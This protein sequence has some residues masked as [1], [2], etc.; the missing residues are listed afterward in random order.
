[1]VHRIIAGRHYRPAQAG[2]PPGPAL[3][4]RER[5]RYGRRVPAG[6]PVIKHC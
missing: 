5:A 3:V 2:P 1:M 4:R 6:L